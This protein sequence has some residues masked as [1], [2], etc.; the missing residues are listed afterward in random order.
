MKRRPAGENRPLGT[1]RPQGSKIDIGVHEFTSKAPYDPSS[2][3]GRYGM[4]KTK[5]A[6]ATPMNAALLN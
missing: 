1:A 2:I 5:I 3:Q 4:T 6:P